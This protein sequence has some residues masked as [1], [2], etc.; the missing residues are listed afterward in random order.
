MWRGAGANPAIATEAWHAV[1][2]ARGVQ[3]I[4][5][6]CSEGIFD[7]P[8]IVVKSNH[9]GELVVRAK[10]SDTREFVSDFTPPGKAI[11]R[12]PSTQRFTPTAN[13]KFEMVCENLGSS[14]D[15]KTPSTGLRKG[16]LFVIRDRSK[17]E[18]P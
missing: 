16:K 13:G 18:R 10:D 12:Q 4:H 8:E 15:A 5:I 7:P 9:P 11:G 6:D 1:A 17:N 3:V 14:P 2:D